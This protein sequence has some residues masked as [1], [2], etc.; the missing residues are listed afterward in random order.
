M[1]VIAGTKRLFIA[2]TAKVSPAG[3]ES[4]VLE[5]SK[6]VLGQMPVLSRKPKAIL[7]PEIL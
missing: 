7:R 4:S 3:F 5:P 1:A 6:A 2:S